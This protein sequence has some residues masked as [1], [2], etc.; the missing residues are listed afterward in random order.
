MAKSYFLIVFSSS[1]SN[2]LQNR[3]SRICEA[4]NADLFSINEDL[5]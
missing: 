3:I 2:Y 1:A 5:E 4:F